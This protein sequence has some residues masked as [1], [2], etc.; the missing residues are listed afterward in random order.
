MQAVEPVDGDDIVGEVGEERVVPP[1][2]P[3]PLLGTAGEAGAAHDQSQGVPTGCVGGLSDLRDTAV[4]P[5]V[6]DQQD[7][8][9]AGAR[10]RLREVQQAQGAALGA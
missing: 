2:R 3:Q 1:V 4:T 9:V 5:D 10:D 6:K 7:S 8:W